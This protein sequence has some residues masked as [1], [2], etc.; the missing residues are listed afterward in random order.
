MVVEDAQPVA[1]NAELI[2]IRTFCAAFS[3]FP[4]EMSHPKYEKC[5]N[6]NG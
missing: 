2:R 6:I 3:T 4:F 1:K 5:E